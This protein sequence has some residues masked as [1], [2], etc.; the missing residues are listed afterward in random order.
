M[1]KEETSTDSK[2][3]YTIHDGTFRV[4]VAESHPEAVARNW[5][6][7]DGKSGTKHERHVKALFGII[8]DIKIHEGDYGK[9]L[10][11]T[12]DEN[13]EGESPIITTGVKSRY[14]EDLLKKL[15]AMKD[16]VSYRFA[17]FDF[18]SE[19]DP[20]RHVTGVS[21]TSQDAEE[22]Y[23]VKVAGF[24]YDVEKKE[25]LNGYPE[26]TDED[27]EDWKFYFMKANKFLLKYTEDNVLPKYV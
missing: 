1:S 21:I 9:N 17:P 27:K 24:F 14:G 15:P 5:E 16:G 23:T 12:L 26:P 13:E 4:K 7:P 8:T 11:I 25:T 2:N 3:Y 22:K 19:K 6:S 20:T 18:P 10:N